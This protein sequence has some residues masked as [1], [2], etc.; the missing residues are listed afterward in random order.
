MLGVKLPA[1]IAKQAPAWK[2]VVGVGFNFKSLS[3]FCYYLT[4]HSPYLKQLYF[5]FLPKNEE[6]RYGDCLSLDAVILSLMRNKKRSVGHCPFNRITFMLSIPVC[7]LIP[8]V[9]AVSQNPDSN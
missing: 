9:W 4:I 3:E 7:I 2:E 1:A 6:K 5:F 8:K